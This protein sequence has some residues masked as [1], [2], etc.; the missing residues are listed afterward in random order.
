M[1]DP[2]YP[3]FVAR[4][5][6]VNTPPG[7]YDTVKEWIREGF[8]HNDSRVLEI[9]CT[10]GFNSYQINRY[11][12]AKVVGIDLSAEAVE[13]AKTDCQGISNLEFRVADAGKLPFKEGQ[14]SHVIISGH[15][16]WV[17]HE[18]REPHV[19]EAMRVL[20]H[21]GM[22]LTSLYY[23]HK[24]PPQELLDQFNTAF[25]TSLSANEDRD[26]WAKILN[27]PE[28]VL[29][30]EKDFLI[31]RPDAARM[32]EYIARF[33]PEFQ[34]GWKKRAELL[35]QNGEFLR[36]VMRVFQKVDKNNPFVQIPRGGIYTWHES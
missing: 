13:K 23:F 22:L 9:G 7:S 17:P 19:R 4:S 33:D 1:T 30:A 18:Y 34:E 36:F 21:D 10:T 2:I 26:Y 27:Q 25:S 15:L 14:F 8:I 20:K 16:P 32:A 31:E 24:N 28:L 12:G 5:G 35:S 3:D 6:Q 11:T 29:E